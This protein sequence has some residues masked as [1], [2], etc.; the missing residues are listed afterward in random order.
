MEADA[1][2]NMGGQSRFRNLSSISDHDV[3]DIAAAVIPT[4]HA[5]IVNARNAVVADDRIAG[6]AS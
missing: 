1:D 2:V 3:P 5:N 4:A 6:N